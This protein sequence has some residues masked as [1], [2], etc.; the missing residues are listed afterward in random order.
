MEIGIK[1]ENQSDNV[2]ITDSRTK[3]GY[4][5]YQEHAVGTKIE[6]DVDRTSNTTTIISNR[7]QILKKKGDNVDIVI[8]TQAP[9]LS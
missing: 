2:E 7:P 9:N 1:L 3:V 6:V 5:L 4:K 8:N